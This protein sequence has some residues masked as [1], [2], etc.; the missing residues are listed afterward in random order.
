MRTLLT[1][2]LVAATGMGLL[3]FGRR[4]LKGVEPSG[5]VP[6][7]TP[8]PKPFELTLDSNPASAVPEPEGSAAADLRAEVLDWNQQALDALDRGEILRALELLQRC[9]EAS[10]D[11]PVLARNWALARLRQAGLMIDSADLEE[12]VAALEL[13][14]N[15]LDALEGDERETVAARIERWRARADHEGSFF[16]SGNRRFELS[17][18]GEQ[19]GLRAS[20]TDLLDRLDKAYQEFGER[21]GAFPLEG[22]R[23]RVVL[24]SPEAFTRLTGLGHWAGGAFDG[25]IRVPIRTGGIDSRLDSVLRHELTHAFVARLGGGSTPAWLNEGLAQFLE[26][27]QVSSLRL[28][29]AKLSCRG[30]PW[31]SLTSLGTNFSTLGDESAI[32]RAY[33]ISLGFTVYLADNYGEELV[34]DLMR[35]GATGS[36]PEVVFRR[37]IGFDLGAAWEDMRQ[38]WLQH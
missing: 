18:D 8:G 31:P 15:V 25:T 6:V 19:Q 4:V 3:F 2:L 9:V 30:A 37:Q 23:L 22:K 10:P 13:V 33:A 24:Y 34:L 12:R 36:S 32:R 35:A 27:R 28:K 14:E 17:Y 7:L 11:D 16:S 5:T 29:A 26:E 20:E 1:I 21:L 38:N